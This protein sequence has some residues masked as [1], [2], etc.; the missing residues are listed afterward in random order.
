M[1][2]VQRVSTRTLYSRLRTAF[3]AAGLVCLALCIAGVF[4]LAK[5]EQGVT[6]LAGDISTQAAP[7][8]DLI[9]TANVLSAKV[10][11]YT[12]T[13][14]E[15]DQ[16]AA[17]EAFTA[18]ARRFGQTRVDMAARPE[19]EV[20]S[21]VVRQSLPSLTAWR[22]GFADYIKFF[23]MADRS[24]RGLASQ[25]TILNILF[26]QLASD[27]GT[28]IPGE[29]APD[30]RK[31]F[32]AALGGLGELQNLILFAATSTDPIYLEKA[33]KTQATLVDS[34]SSAYEKAP[35][36]DLRDF[37]EDVL[38]KT[39]DLRDEIVGLQASI[40]GRDDSQAR[41]LEAGKRL[42]AELD[43]VG[44]RAMTQTVA[45]ANEASTGLQLT[46]YCLAAAAILVPLFGFGA[47]RSLA[48]GISRHLAPIAGRVSETASLTFANT[49]QAETDAAA[50]AAAAEEQASA[51]AQLNSGAADVAK[52]ASENLSRMREAT[53]LSEST[54]EHAASGSQTIATMNV[55]MKDIGQCGQR[56]RQA[57]TAIDEIAFQTNLLAL[58]A[59][60]EAARAGEAG[61]GFAI[62][63]E[64]V[65]RLA[66]RS[67]I[68]AKE[69][70]E[71]VDSTQAATARGVET[72]GQVGRDFATITSEIERLRT[73]VRDTVTASQKQ[74]EEMQGIISML[75]ELGHST[76]GTSDQATRGAQI[77]STLHEHAARLE[78]DSAELTRFLSMGARPAVDAPAPDSA[79][80]STPPS[81]NLEPSPSAAIA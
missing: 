26:T 46:V 43:P 30:F 29:R 76:A 74:T 18:T 68:S 13:H 55:A 62:V 6:S 20:I 53:R 37:L 48:L 66:Q 56:I 33:L 45:T 72:A 14:A 36:S 15:A 17:N 47:G 49:R 54:S 52:S 40:K 39:K 16:L 59:A 80:P 3:V 10:A 7:A 31:K 60:I 69:T 71:I 24:F 44:Q 9:R 75:K 4:E 78:T 21:R 63:A 2:S 19:G 77:A 23:K 41:M 11:T 57:V 79:T 34:I 65:R 67:A 22:G 5:V 32:E 8:A 51:L 28:L 81:P 27:D 1:N 64:E 38:S 35:P 73:Q 42:L 50:L 61:R 58:N 70:A 25:S 12:R